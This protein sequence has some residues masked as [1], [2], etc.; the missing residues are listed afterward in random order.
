MDTST[1]GPFFRFILLLSLSL[2]PS[3]LSFVSSSS[4]PLLSTT[5]F[6]LQGKDFTLWGWDVFR[7]ESCHVFSLFFS[8]CFR[9]KTLILCPLLKLNWSWQLSHRQWLTVVSLMIHFSLFSLFSFFGPCY[10]FTLCSE[11]LHSSPAIAHE[12]E[13]S[14]E[15]HR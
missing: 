6:Q 13:S 8:T 4:S 14:S 12:C 1:R 11:H 9:Q 10:A 7:C 2:S 3:S 15:G 5:L